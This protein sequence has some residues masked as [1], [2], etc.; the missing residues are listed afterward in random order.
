MDSDCE[1]FLWE[2]CHGPHVITTVTIYDLRKRPIGVAQVEV[3]ATS[4]IC[5]RHSSSTCPAR[6]A[7]LLTKYLIHVIAVSHG[8]VGPPVSRAR[9]GAPQP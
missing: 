4:V 8:P 3:G 1:H 7:A 2:L 9:R 5:G 6:S